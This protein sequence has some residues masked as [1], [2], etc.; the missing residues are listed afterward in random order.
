VTLTNNDP[1]APASMLA[2]SYPAALL[3][4]SLGTP[5]FAFGT[6]ELL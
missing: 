1:A 2:Q 4:P 5:F 3:P 6:A